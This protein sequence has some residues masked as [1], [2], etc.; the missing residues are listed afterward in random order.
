MGLLGLGSLLLTL[1]WSTASD[2]A[3][4]ATATTTFQ[5]TAN[6]SVACT[7]I[8]T[9]LTFPDYVAAA[10]TGQSTITVRCTNTAQW[11][12]GLNA[13]TGPSA[14][15]TTRK[16]TGPAPFHL[17]YSLS[18]DPTHTTNWGHTVG[19]D[20]VSGSG[21]GGDQVVTVYGRIPASQ[22]VGP[23]GYA[24]TITATITF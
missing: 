15:V 14:T 24:D 21:T 9:D 13:G 18:T 11:N 23:G 1:G 2:K 16:M 8:A 12:V 17:N 7:I 4:A 19:T 22:A 10:V 3:G 6:V 20:T 5:V